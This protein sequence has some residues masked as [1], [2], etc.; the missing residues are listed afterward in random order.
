[1]V[2]GPAVAPRSVVGA[3]RHVG[4][5]PATATRLALGTSNEVWGLERPQVVITAYGPHHDVSVLRARLQVAQA[6]QDV[7]PFVRLLEVLELDGVVA[8]WERLPLAGHRAPDP[9]FWEAVGASL[10]RLSEL[11]L[12]PLAAA[13]RL[14]VLHDVGPLGDELTRLVDE[15]LLTPAAA[16]L[17]EDVAARLSAELPAGPPALAHGDAHLPNL[18]RPAGGPARVVLCDVDELGR[19]PALWD[20]AFVLDPGRRPGLRPDERR[21]LLGGRGVDEPPADLVRA[22]ARLSHLRRTVRE[23][24]SPGRE[25][26]VW[27]RL[28]VAAWAAVR[29]DWALDLHPVFCLPR[30]RQLALLARSAPVRPRQAGRPRRS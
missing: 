23:L 7:A 22:M 10:R 13:G 11:P 12:E 14:P 27:S 19:A 25:A 1:M 28:R 8:V 9:A 17:L 3:V 5:D 30:T 15:R 29:S 21:A 2:S 6:L 20:T 18:L 26:R 16:R 4:G 24:R